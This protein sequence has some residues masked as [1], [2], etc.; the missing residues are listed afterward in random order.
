MSSSPFVRCDPCIERSLTRLGVAQS[1]PSQ[2]PAL[3]QAAQDM[4]VQLFVLN[5]ENTEQLYGTLDALIVV[6]NPEDSAEQNVA[7]LHP[8][9]A[10]NSRKLPVFGIHGSNPKNEDDDSTIISWIGDNDYQVGLQSGQHFLKHAVD[11]NTTALQTAFVASNQ[12]SPVAQAHFQGLQA[13][14][15]NTSMTVEWL[16]DLQRCAEYDY[17]LL[18]TEELLE[19]IATSCSSDTQ[20]GATFTSKNVYA[21]LV[22]TNNPLLFGWRSQEHL[23]LSASV[24]NAALYA[25]TRKTW[26]LPLVE[27]QYTAGKTLTTIENVPSDS[28]TVCHAASFPVCVDNGQEGDVAQANN[29]DNSGVCKCTSRPALR[30]GG[31]VHGHMRDIFWDPVFA[32]AQQAADDMKITLDIERFPEP[33]DQELLYRQMA[34]RIRNLCDNGID[35]IFVT[36]PSDDVLIAVQQ[37]LDLRIPVISINSGQESSKALGLPHH[38][39]MDEY[40]G[41]YGAGERMIAAGM[42]RAYCVDHA[43]GNTALIE[44]CR[45]FK[46]AIAASASPDV[47]FVEHFAVPP[48]NKEQYLQI[49][50]STVGEDWSGV[51]LL[52]MGPNQI[53]GLRLVLERHPSTIVGTFDVNDDVYAGIESNQLLFGIDQQPF[54]QGNL[55]IYLLTWMAYTKESFQEHMVQSGPDFVESVPLPEY[56][57]CESNFFAVC[58]DRPEENMNYIPSALLAVGYTLFGVLF[59]MCVAALAWT[60]YYRERWV[61]KVSQPLF[62]MIVLG[63]TFLSSLS[64]IFLGFETAYRYEQDEAGGAL[65]VPNPDIQRVDAA[66]MAVPWFYGLGFVITF[67]ALFAKIQRVKLIY[68]AGM[69]MLRKKVGLR[70]VAYIAAFML[71]IEL[72]ILVTWQVVAPLQWQREVLLYDSEQFSLSS[73]GGCSGGKEGWYFFLVLMIFHALCLFYALILGFQTKDINSDLAESSQ[74]SLVVLFMFQVLVVAVPISALVREN[75]EVFYFVRVSAIFLQNITVL[76]L[77]FGPK[78]WK[79]SENYNGLRNTASL[80]TLPSTRRGGSLNIP[81]NNPV[82]M[83]FQERSRVSFATAEESGRYSNDSGYVNTPDS[84][85]RRSSA[86]LSS[87][88]DD[89]TDVISNIYL[90]EDDVV[91]NGWSEIGFTSEKQALAVIKAGKRNTRPWHRRVLL[92]DIA[93][94]QD[95]A[96]EDAVEGKTAEKTE[97]V[98]SERNQFDSTPTDGKSADVYSSSHVFGR[99]E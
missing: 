26:T 82:S 78:F 31:V 80:S 19:N 40:A 10:M 22:S 89:R 69:R 77:I 33:T 84:L 12:K 63:G 66:C 43:F 55:P 61:V 5:D 72:A 46:E 25:T 74:L 96:D 39:G 68:Q 20:V 81:P 88:L 90:S 67:S 65:L 9:L 99:N 59:L 11:K 97:G 36:I 15:Q 91:D 70:D 94:M 73:V 18:H 34:A 98:D 24:V 28:Y 54:L 14:A 75:A 93:T 35:G 42:T 30:L 95:N 49:V 57:F 45:G 79:L 27:Q 38:I 47:V 21:S 1:L 58:P 7:Q 8:L 53:P 92:T 64:I 2:W 50:E 86:T 37:C 44:R 51:G 48:D 76:G 85:P 32:S 13:A 87:G 83:A 16:T 62:L 3:Q 17:A 23:A 41:G 71:T 52:S 4:N 56:A 60:W 29:T 6:R